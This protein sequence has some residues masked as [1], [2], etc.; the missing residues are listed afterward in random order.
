MDCTLIYYESPHRILKTLK[1]MLKI[2]DEDR[3][4]CVVRE[5]SK[6][7]ETYHHGTLSTLIEHFTENKPKGEIVLLVEGNT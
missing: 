1:Q 7:Y 2:F 6:I 4:A 5:L 3:K